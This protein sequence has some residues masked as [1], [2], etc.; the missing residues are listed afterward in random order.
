MFIL[1]GALEQFRLKRI[2]STGP[3]KLSMV[4]H[5]VRLQNVPL[6]PLP[7]IKGSVAFARRTDPQAQEIKKILEKISVLRKRIAYIQ[8]FEARINEIKRFLYHLRML[9]SMA[10]DPVPEV[11]L[12]RMMELI[13]VQG[14]VHK[15]SRVIVSGKVHSPSFRKAALGWLQARSTPALRYKAGTLRLRWASRGTLP[16]LTAPPKGVA[17][18]GPHSTLLAVDAT[19][20]MVALAAGGLLA[21]KEGKGAGVTGT[22]RGRLN[23]ALEAAAR[24][25]GLTIVRRGRRA[26]LVTPGQEDQAKETLRQ[27][28]APSSKPEKSSSPTPGLSDLR[29]RLLLLAGGRSLAV[30]TDEG[31]AA[32]RVKKGSKLGRTSSRVVALDK[33]GVTVLWVDGKRRDRLT[34]P[35]GKPKKK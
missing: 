35:L 14:I 25:Q 13:R 9:G 6:K 12:V 28:L 17:R 29:L 26:L 31:G 20:T 24:S 32:H 15:G 7:R 16:R 27:G 34:I 3:W 10:R 22:I 8:Q 33:N 23:V 18:G 5:H 19:A 11:E 4:G 2:K 30:L 21:V 1:P